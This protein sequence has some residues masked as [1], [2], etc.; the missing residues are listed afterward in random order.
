MRKLQDTAEI[1]TGKHL[2]RW[3][4]P[5]LQRCWIWP[6][7]FLGH[8]PGIQHKSASIDIGCTHKCSGGCSHGSFQL[9]WTYEAVHFCFAG[10][11][12]VGDD[13][14]RLHGAGVHGKE[15]TVSSPRPP[16]YCFGPVWCLGNHRCDNELRL[17]SF[18]AYHNHQLNQ[19]KS[20]HNIYQ[21]FAA[22]L[23][24]SARGDLQT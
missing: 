4:Q 18:A 17:R 23:L 8:V 16:W 5:S 22:F 19:N 9:Q 6:W 1:R 15:T 3:Y 24:L 20:P 12:G 10:P 7:D 2:A 13:V 14:P 11:L 21:L